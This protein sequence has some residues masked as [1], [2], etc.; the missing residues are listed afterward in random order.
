MN[1]NAYIIARNVEQG[2]PAIEDVYEERFFISEV[3]AEQCLE[4]DFAPSI[5]G[6]YG[7]YCVDA[8]VLCALGDEDSLTASSVASGVDDTEVTPSV[9]TTTEESLEDWVEAFYE[10]H[11]TSP[12]TE[13]SDYY[14]AVMKLPDDSLLS[15]VPMFAI[16]PKEYFDKTGNLYGDSLAVPEEILP[17]GFEEEMESVYGFDGDEAKGKFVLT[18]LGFVEHNIVKDDAD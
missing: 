13:P 16:T 5:R 15:D 11:E 9:P 7:I 18:T 4:E 1:I 8:S 10:R 12:S 6:D 14:F 3:E 2:L 17:N